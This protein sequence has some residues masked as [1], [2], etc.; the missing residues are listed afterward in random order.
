MSQRA[1]GPYSRPTTVDDEARVHVAHRG[2]GEYVDPYDVAVGEWA[3]WLPH[4]CDEWII[5]QGDREH[6][7]QQVRLLID[8]L[9]EALAA[10]EE[11]T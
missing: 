3:V 8:S 7:A 5:G 9:T 1:V 6:V 4:D 2:E 10:L 11:T